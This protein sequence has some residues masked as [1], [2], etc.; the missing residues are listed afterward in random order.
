VAV[1][2]RLIENGQQTIVETHGDFM[3]S[4]THRSIACRRAFTCR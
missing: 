3:S 4:K 2:G 1:A